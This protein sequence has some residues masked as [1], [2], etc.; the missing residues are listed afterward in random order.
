MPYIATTQRIS[1]DTGI[2]ILRPM[3]YTHPLADAAY[4]D[5]GLH[6]YWWGED[7]WVAPI[8]APAA[9]DNCSSDTGV[10]LKAQMEARQFAAGTLKPGKKGVP[11]ANATLQ[12]RNGLTA[13]TVW[14]PPGDWIEWFSWGLV[15]GA[16]K[17]GTGGAATGGFS[18]TAPD[19]FNSGPGS[20]IARNYS[21]KEMPVFSRPGSIITM[22]TLPDASSASVP[23]LSPS[24][25]PLD[26]A[27]AG[28]GSLGAPPPAGGTS[29]LGLAGTPYSDMTLYV[30][31]LAPDTL[32]RNSVLGSASHTTRT[33][34]YEDDGVSKAAEESAVFG[35]SNV[36]CTWKRV[37]G[38]GAVGG[39]MG[40][41][42]SAMGLG[43]AGGGDTDSVS[44][45][46]SPPELGAGAHSLSDAGIPDT[47][48]FTWRFIGSW[49]PEEVRVNGALV[50]RDQAAVPDASGDHSGW[51]P[52]QN[53][54]AY[55]GDTLSTWVRVGVPHATVS[56]F[57]ISLNFP[58][59][60]RSD[61]AL[62]T[63]GFSR[64]V[65]RSLV[66]KDEV[67][68]GYSLIYPS[69]VED[70]LNISASATAFSAAAG[71]GAVKKTLEILPA[72]MRNA[73]SRLDV[74]ASTFA[75]TPSG[76]VLHQRCLGA[77]HDGMETYPPTQLSQK[78]PRTTIAAAPQKYG[79]NIEHPRGSM[80]GATSQYSSTPGQDEYSS[81]EG[82]E[83]YYVQ[84]VMWGT[85]N[86][87][88]KTAES[89]MPP[90]IARRPIRSAAI[91]QNGEKIDS[92]IFDEDASSEDFSEL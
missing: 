58:A 52:Q 33:R 91:N 85:T 80:P 23:H 21:I 75:G 28:D 13:W 49:I 9:K 57:T 17:P 67:D 72:T 3:Y 39:L 84:H 14:V 44:C 47:R 87:P 1:H 45:T 46:V 92:G 60:F 40:S 4:T 89:G 62:L 53:A 54:W 32:P 29:M 35:W 5:Q 20:F 56:P 70:I 25:L 61:D 73:I 12:Q 2:Q 64:S 59:G 81:M 76:F 27:V 51:M 18:K 68:R 74:I 82:I 86:D 26:G 69:D 77:L 36:T 42:G 48:A 41:L 55:G 78:D 31:P 37:K 24:R 43:S 79:S 11:Y 63:S 6:Q 38:G 66:C 7:I 15:S 83:D 71:A 90:E 30:L 34:L 50:W 19:H 16:V 8:A 22:R 88:E 10:A 65:A